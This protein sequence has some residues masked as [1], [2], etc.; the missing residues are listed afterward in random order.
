VRFFSK[1]SSGVGKN[2]QLLAL[3]SFWLRRSYSHNEPLFWLGQHPVYVTELLIGLHSLAFFIL[4]V[5]APTE[6]GKW[7]VQNLAFH[8]SDVLNKGYV[9]Q[10][11][12]YIFVPFISPWFIMN[13]LTLYWFGRELEDQLGRKGFLFLYFCLTICPMLILSALTPLIGYAVFNGSDILHFAVFMAFASVLP[14]TELFIGRFKAIW[15]SLVLFAVYSLVAIAQRDKVVLISL[16]VSS[17]IASF[18]V[19]TPFFASFVEWLETRREKEMEAKAQAKRKRQERDRQIQEQTIDE[20]LDKISQHG[21]HSLTKEE[22]STLE[23]ARANLLKRD[24]S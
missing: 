22:R 7:I 13:M 14:D 4:A 21:M 15:V 6:A 3:M 16:W 2:G 11:I 8:S 10:L 20:I 17:G 5:C 19:R 1:K 18:A 24:K 12:T 9:W 23:R